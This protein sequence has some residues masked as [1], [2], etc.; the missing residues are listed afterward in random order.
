M[1]AH[2]RPVSRFPCHTSGQLAALVSVEWGPG[3]RRNKQRAGGG[4]GRRRDR[5]KKT[6]YLKP[7]ARL[8]NYRREH[9]PAI[10]LPARGWFSIWFP[11]HTMWEH[12]RK[13]RGWVRSDRSIRWDGHERCWTVASAHFPHVSRELLRRYRSVLI[14][15]KYNPREKCNSS[16]HNAQSFL[17]TCSCLAKYY[18]RGKWRSGWR[19]LGEF[20]G[21]REGRPW[22]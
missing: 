10:G 16:R 9:L 20:S 12:E 13:L 11:A 22:H 4:K 3:P 19:T 14:G 7:L 21:R 18:G 2:D 6:E 1:V 15:R 5:R 8:P 17:C